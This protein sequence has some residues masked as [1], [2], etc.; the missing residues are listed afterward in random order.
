MIGSTVSH[1]RITEKLGGGGMGVVYKAEDTR[2]KRTVALKFLPEDFAADERAM[3][4]FQRE[5]QAASTLD[6]PNICVIHDIDESGG[7]PFI[8]MEYLEGQTLKDL[9]QGRPLPVH[10]LIGLA[11]EI[12]DALDAA[13]GKGIVHRDLKPANIFVISRG[14]AK[15]LD[16][17]LAKLLEDGQAPASPTAVTRTVEDSLTN[18]GTTVGTV[19]YMSPEQARGEELDGRTDL[20]SFGVVLYEMATGRQAFTGSTSAVIFD[21]I[22][23]KA[24]VAPVRLNPALPADL[25]RIINKALEKDRRLRYQTAADL[26]ADLERLKRE[27]DSGRAAAAAPQEDAVPAGPP[28]RAGGR[29]WA[30]RAT[31]VGAVL[32]LAAA[33]ALLLPGRTRVTEPPRLVNHVQLTAAVGVEDFP[34]WSPDGRMLAYESEQAGNLDIWVVQAG[35]GQPVN[36]TADS[37]AA[38]MHPSWSPDGQWIAFFSAREGGG[39]FVMPGVGGTARKVASWPPG[40]VYPAQPQWSPDSTQLA[41]AMDQRRAPHLEILTLSS[42]TARKLPLPQQPRNNAVI[43][44]RW[45][46][47]GRW[48]AYGRSISTFAATSEL[49]MTRV[50]DGESIQVTDGTRRDSG[51]AWPPGSGALYFISDRSGTRDLWRFELGRDGLPHGEP[52]QV[53]AGIEMAHAVFCADG[54]RLAYSRGRRIANAFRVALAGDRQATWADAEQLTFDEAEVESIDVSPDGRILLSSDRSGNWDVWLLPAPGAELQRLTTDAGVDAGPRW[55]PHGRSLLYYSSRTGHRE[56]WTMPLGGGPARQVTSGD[57][58]SYYAAWSPDGQEI[59]AEGQGVFVVPAQGG[60]KR[61]LVDSRA[62]LH[63]DWSPDGRWVA[64]DS[65]REGAS[66]LWRVPASGGQLEKLTESEGCCPRW[67]PDGTLVYYAGLGSRAN[68]VWSVAAGSGKERQVTA[69]TGRRGA[70]RGV[71]LAADRGYLYFAWQETR[72]DIWVADLVQPSRR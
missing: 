18:P 26:R 46:P 3:K 21:A 64:F 53:D 49:W 50:A 48:F 31:A 16:F 51:P 58:E 27:S 14:H 55:H 1:Y 34:S 39:Y 62:S 22:L 52:H 40:G 9:I 69:L 2:L 67:S 28:P 12:A 15:I 19:A 65:T 47:D 42:G 57:S 44:L 8:A 20:F 37:P 60:P 59:A 33:A 13:H 68:N 70:L 38:D 23:H 11:A 56:I 61:S 43:D 72:G 25:E 6:H 45:S 35:S 10:E 41:F 5:A 7:R 4:R 30:W 24:P 63:P 71:S 36:R 54:T 29:R 66:S 17:G 32:V